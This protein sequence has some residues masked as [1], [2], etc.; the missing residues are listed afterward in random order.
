MRRSALL[1][2]LALFVLLLPGAQ[3]AGAAVAGLPPPSS[4]P[5]R[6]GG[7]GGW[8]AAGTGEL[9]AFWVDAFHD[10]IKTPAQVSQLIADAQTANANTLIVQVRRRGD[11]YYNES[12]EPRADDPALD[13]A[14]FDPLASVIAAAHGADPPLQVYAWVVAFPVWTSTYTTTDTTRHVYYRHGCGNGCSWDDPDNWVTYRYNSGNPVPDYALDPGHPAAASY[15]VDVV[16]YL[17]RHYD[18]DGIALDY[19]RYGGQDYGYNKVSEDRFHAAYGG[20]G[21]PSPT[22]AD[23][24]AWRREQVTKVVRRIYLEA[25]AV[26]PD[27]VVAAATI[28]WGNGPDQAGGWEN[29]SAY[30]SVF[31]DWRAWLDDGIL[32]LALPMNYDREHQPPQDQYFRNWVE[33]EKDHQYDRGVAVAQG[34]Y[35]NYIGGSITQAQAVLQPSAA[36]HYALGTS[37]YSYASTNCGGLP[38]SEFYNALANPNP[39]G[40]PPFSTWVGPP[41][42]AWKTS[43]T[44]G[45]LAGWA[46]GASS[47]LDRASV[48]VS[49]P[50]SFGLLTDGNGFFGATDL[51]PGDY[52]ITLP[53]PAASPLYATVTPGRVALATV[54]ASQ[55]PALRAVLVDA[56]HDGFKTP[57]QVDVLLADARAAHLNVVVV[58]MRS[59]GQIYYDSP[60]EPRA[61]DPEL[62]ANFDPLAYLLQQAHVGGQPIAVYAWLPALAVWSGDL[63]QLP[64]GHVLQAHQDWLTEDISGTRPANGAYFLDPGHPG[65]LS[66]TVGLAMDLVSRYPLDGLLLDSLQYPN[67]GSD[68]GYAVWGY[69]PVSVQRF[70]ARYGG[71]GDPAPGDPTWTAWR[72]EQLTALL[73]QVYLRCTGLRPRLRISAV[74]I[75][76]GDGPDWTGGWE[77]SRAYGELLQ[78]WRGWLQE[79]IVDL[80][81]PMNYDR[82]YN[83]DQQAWYDHWLSWEA[84]QRYNRGLL[85]LQAAYLNYPEQTLVQAQE[86]LA[87]SSAVGF[88]SYIPA[89]LYADPDG[90]SRYIQPPRQPWYYSPQAEWWLGRSLALPYGYTDPADGSFYVT[91][92][93]FA[94]IVPTPTL[95][96]KDTPSLG[97]AAGWALGPGLVPLTVPV[98]ITLS[99]P[100]SRVL[101][102][103]G[104]GFFGAVDLPP[105]YYYAQVSGAEPS[106]AILEG[107]VVAG[108]VT[109]LQPYHIYLPLVIRGT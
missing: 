56:A 54:A 17:V 93:I 92:P 86:G 5:E 76:W 10:G 37:F 68:V 78:D 49:G 47:P 44:A 98:T 20:S 24:M 77:S 3:P 16:L 85:V 73:R 87:P 82:E 9:R 28:A 88:S 95:P 53:A 103:D 96:W 12:V 55:Q 34:A 64:A 13:P 27:L 6:G 66:Y 18:V 105:G 60:Y 84:G 75:A 38:N 109:W 25:L 42:L 14:P 21:H 15:T 41:D 43:P 4:M 11:S 51:P 81:A 57:D 62:A 58:Q 100:A 89:D 97:H 2:V 59:L 7:P 45:H 65:V 32:D 106:Q 33:W 67:V 72:R 31:Q 61:A 107:T 48:Q 108:Q 22:D 35:L 29:S 80:A 70:H 90:N 69:N 104:S 102:N 26:K 99:G 36:G 39:Y 1:Y 83:G 8:G 74:G 50:I 71:G 40:D 46:I 23:W 63:G 91:S 101:Q 79:G 52:T 19:I 94:G 30:K